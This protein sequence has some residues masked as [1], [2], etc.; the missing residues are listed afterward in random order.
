VLTLQPGGS[1]APP[2]QFIDWNSLYTEFLK[3]K[4]PV[5]IS[6]DS[7]FVPSGKVTLPLATYD[8]QG[9][10]LW[11][12]SG[13]NPNGGTE[14]EIPDGGIIKNLLGL[15]G[16]YGAL[17]LDTASA[18]IEPLQFDGV[19][20]ASF[21][22]TGGCS[23][24]QQGAAAVMRVA[25]GQSLF[26]TFNGEINLNSFNSFGELAHLSAATSVL[27]FSVFNGFNFFNASGKLFSGVVGSVLAYLYDASWIGNPANPNFLGTTNAPIAIDK[28][29]FEVYSALTPANWAG[30]PPIN[31][32]S[33][34]DRLAAVVAVLNG[35]PIP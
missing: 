11:S 35:G 22:V 32:N 18:S 2:N 34:I 8:M 6:F 10:A 26:I 1:A 31:V 21:I 16:D 29:A 14:V 12:T 28:A 7:T 24:F 15:N 27:S 17:Q 30:L 4:G 13:L 23:F 9:R 33:A 20:F 19:P 3:T 5:R 25:S